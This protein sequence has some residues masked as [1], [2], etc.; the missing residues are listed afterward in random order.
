RLT[1]EGAPCPVVDG[2]RALAAPAGR[3]AVEWRLRCPA[4]A[5]L[6][7]ESALFR[8]VAP[9]HLHFA[10]VRGDHGVVEAALRSD[11]PGLDVPGPEAEAAALPARAWTAY[12]PL[13]VVHIATGVDHLVFLLALL[14]LA[15]RLGEVA[16]IVTGFTLAHSLTL[17]LAAFGR[18]RPDGAAVEALI[19]LSI[20]LVAAENAWLLAGRPRALPPI[21]A[22]LLGAAALGSAFGVGGLPALTLAGL[23]LFVPAYFA[24]VARS[25]RPMRLRTAIA[26]AFGLVHGF[27]FAGVLAEL[28]LPPGRLAAA[29]LGFNLGVE[30]GQ[31]LAVAAAWPLLRALHRWRDGVPGRL[32]AEVAT[33]GVAGLGVF[34]L[35]ARAYGSAG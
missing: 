7:V 28:Q 1:A 11:G 6:R 23:A 9:G 15:S 16:T 33:A 35:V 26:F 10:R 32:V 3:A 30:A 29:L 5:G 2:P 25:R 18:L 4:A 21:L 17:A 19:G 13:G 14:L 12:L 20:A 24:L 31:L 8:E 34:W 22:G 27:G